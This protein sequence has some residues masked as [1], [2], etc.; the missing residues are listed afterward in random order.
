MEMRIE[1][2]LFV[3]TYLTIA[4]FQKEQVLRDV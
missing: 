2:L 1:I 3:N 4:N